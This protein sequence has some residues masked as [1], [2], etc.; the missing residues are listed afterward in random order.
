MHIKQ[1][2]YNKPGSLS[3]NIQQALQHAALARGYAHVRDSM[4]KL[5][6]MKLKT[7]LTVSNSLF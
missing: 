2:S 3:L 6:A 5:F 1:D 7:T 4:L